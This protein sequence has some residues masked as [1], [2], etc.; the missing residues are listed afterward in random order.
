MLALTGPSLAHQVKLIRRPRSPEALVRSET[1][2]EKWINHCLQTL[3]PDHCLQTIPDHCLQTV[4]DCPET[5]SRQSR[6]VVS[7]TFENSSPTDLTFLATTGCDR[8]TLLDTVALEVLVALFKVFGLHM[9]TTAADQAVVLATRIQLLVGARF[10]HDY[11][12]NND[13][14]SG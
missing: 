11:K 6:I 13:S 4:P 2:R 7:L 1:Y 5:V 10:F 12:F 3:S 14:L 9:V 8:L